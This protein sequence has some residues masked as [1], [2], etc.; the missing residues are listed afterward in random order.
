MALLGGEELFERGFWD[1]LEGFEDWAGC[2]GCE[3]DPSKSLI[4][5]DFK[6]GLV[7]GK[8]LMDTGDVASVEARA[9]IGPAGSGHDADKSDSSS[10]PRL[11]LERKEGT[12]NDSPVGARS[13]AA[14]A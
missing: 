13:K 4:E 6:T 2:G 7:S 9:V 10:L 12:G 14:P 11:V 5:T 1:C 3:D 8:E